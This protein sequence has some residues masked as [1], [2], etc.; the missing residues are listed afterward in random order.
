MAGAQA[1]AHVGS[2]LRSQTPRGA[3]ES[4]P[5]PPNDGF[6]PWGTRVRRQKPPMDQRE[7]IKK[8]ASCP[9]GKEICLAILWRPGRCDEQGCQHWH[10]DPKLLEGKKGICADYQFGHCEHELSGNPE[11]CEYA[12]IGVGKEMAEQVSHNKKSFGMAN[13]GKGKGGKPDRALS[14]SHWGAYS[15]FTS[16]KGEEQKGKGKE[17]QWGGKDG[18]KGKQKG[19]KKGG[20]GTGKKGGGKPGPI[21]SGDSAWGTGVNVNPP[22]PAGTPAAAA[23]QPIGAKPN[24]GGE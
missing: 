24:A 9:A 11:A 14:P 5:P 1:G 12:H 16:Q 19:G 3:E 13:Y 20:W 10:P 23:S 2:S 4:L 21:H 15:P 18:E 7:Y 6:D 17:G 8:D 22:Q